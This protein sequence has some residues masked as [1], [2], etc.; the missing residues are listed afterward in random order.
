MVQT[1]LALPDETVGIGPAQLLHDELD[2]GA[3]LGRVGVATV[4]HVLRH[5]VRREKNH[6]LNKTS[7]NVIMKKKMNKNK[8]KRNK[9]G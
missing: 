4:H 6:N 7:V 8:R 1:Y 5:R 2:G 9:A 3:H